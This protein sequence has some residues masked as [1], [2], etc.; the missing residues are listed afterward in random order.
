LISGWEYWSDEYALVDRAGLVH[1]YPRALVLRSVDGTMRAIPAAARRASTGRG[2]AP[3]RLIVRLNYDPAAR[4]S[5]RRLAQSEMILELLKNTPQ[6]MTEVE[7]AAP[8][9]RL[10]AGAACYAGTRG[11]ATEAVERLRELVERGA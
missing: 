2:A 4:W 1:P 11:E 9:A 6:S 8:L 5:L 3:V 10:A 7:M